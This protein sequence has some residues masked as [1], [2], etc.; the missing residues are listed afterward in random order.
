LK[1]ERHEREGRI[2]DSL[3]GGGKSALGAEGFPRSGW[4]N[5]V[6]ELNHDAFGCLFAHARD[7][8]ER[9][10]IAIGHCSTQGSDV[11]PA[12]HVEGDLWANAANSVNEQAEHVAFL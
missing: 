1:I 5:L 8:R 9:F 12:E 4:T 11:H 7:L 6:P 3:V 2:V 10:N